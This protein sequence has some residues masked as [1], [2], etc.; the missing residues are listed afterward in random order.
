MITKNQRLKVHIM[1]E[2][3]VVTEEMESEGQFS[4][5]TMGKAIVRFKWWIIGAT[6][7]GALGGYLGFSFGLNKT[8]EKMVSSFG[9]DINVKP[10]TELVG[11]KITDEDRANQQLYLSDGS[12]FSY[13]DVISEA[14]MKAVQEANKDAFGKINISKMAKEGG[15]Q[16]DR[17]SYTD[18][19]TGKTVYEYPAKYKISATKKYFS[20]K[21]QAKDFIEA[22]VNYELT[23]AE[24][25]NNIYEVE[26]YLS[27]NS[28]SNYGLYVKN[29]KDQYTAINDC[30]S[31]LLEEFANSST[32]D[33]QGSSLNKVYGVFTAS[34]ANGAGSTTIDK[35]EGDLYN[36][37]L[38]DYTDTSLSE[39]SLKSQ[40]D[41]LKQS[42]KSNLLSLETLRAQLDKLTSSQIIVQ[43]ETELTKEVVRLNKQI[44]EVSEQNIF[45][46]KELRN[47]GY[48]V[49]NTVTLDNVDT[50]AYAGDS[51]EGI[52][53]SFK[54][55][56]ATWKA[57]CDQ[58]KI[59][60]AKTAEK[61]A[62]D[63]TTVG[64]VYG[65][66]N[67]KYN[68]QVNFYTAGVAKLEG[69]MSNF[70]GLAAG[71]IG[72][73]ILATLVVTFVYIS[74]KEKEEK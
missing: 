69:H 55:S 31:D 29:L 45:Y 1:A 18:S 39:A 58:F 38:I 71:A 67:N 26:N 59:D 60:L 52:I 6:A 21:Q 24:S 17:A 48:T 62:A 8:R 47:L 33:A 23:V 65:F 68:N 3:K 66:V 11:D 53:Q 32:A 43:N 13:T 37:H 28:N 12:L 40:A 63:R 2:E 46:A 35:L 19:T 16:I 5:R 27:E 7:V 15:M 4:F 74:K 25:A 49:P 73:F 20:S 34:Y 64:D 36:K 10:K 70:I 50:I 44:L 9:Y 61:L 42:L 22:L 56:D 30:Y 57:A 14:R 72:G 41:A 54:A 51:E